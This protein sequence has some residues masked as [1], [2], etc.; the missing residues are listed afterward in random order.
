M[1]KKYFLTLFFVISAAVGLIS[2]TSAKP[3][4]LEFIDTEYDFGS[5][6]D[7]HEPIVHEFAFTNTSSEP[8]AVLS[9][10]TGCGCTRPQYP[11]EPVKSGKTAKIKITFLPKG[12]KGEINK[13]IRVRFRGAK[14]RKAERITLRLHGH[15]TPAKD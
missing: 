14:A 4:S 12:Q 13:D 10:S 15:V 5:I 11:L 8:V 2:L 1:V 3:A 9:V 7:S 6:S